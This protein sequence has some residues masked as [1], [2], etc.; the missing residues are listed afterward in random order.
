MPFGEE[1]MPVGKAPMWMK[2]DPG[3]RGFSSRTEPARALVSTTATSP[4]VVWVTSA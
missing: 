3:S 4:R 1:T 2:P